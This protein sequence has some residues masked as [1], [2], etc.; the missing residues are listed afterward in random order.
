MM[1]KKKSIHFLNFLIITLLIISCSKNG[2]TTNTSTKTKLDI[3]GTWYYL[4]AKDSLYNLSN[5]LLFSA[6]Y[7]KRDT[8]VY[9]YKQCNYVIIQNTDTCLA[10]WCGLGPSIIPSYYKFISDSSFIEE[11]ISITSPFNG[12]GYD[13]AKVVKISNSLLILYRKGVDQSLD[14]SGTFKNFE[15]HTLDSLYK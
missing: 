10:G 4:S 15:I 5:G 12:F 14:S 6:S 13:T 9:M 3:S 11:A 1:T 2:T 7:Y 8:S